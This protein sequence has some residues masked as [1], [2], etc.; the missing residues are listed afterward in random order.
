[1]HNQMMAISYLEHISDKPQTWINSKLQVPN[2]S[3]SGR[4]QWNSIETDKSGDL[5]FGFLEFS[6]CPQLEL[7]NWK[8]HFIQIF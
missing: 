5:E 7:L 3:T 1:M 2:L 8:T 4:F 6:S